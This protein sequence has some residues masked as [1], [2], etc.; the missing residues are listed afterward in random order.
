[1]VSLLYCLHHDSTVRQR[2]HHTNPTIKYSA[3]QDFVVREYPFLKSNLLIQK[4]TLWKKGS[5]LSYFEA[6]PHLS[7][8]I[9]TK[10]PQGAKIALYYKCTY[11]C[12]R[13][14]IVDVYRSYFGCWFKWTMDFMSCFCMRVSG[15][16]LQVYDGSSVWVVCRRMRVAEG[17]LSRVPPMFST[18]WSWNPNKK[19]SA[20][21]MPD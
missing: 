12:C 17:R 19:I 1:M 16:W 10:V 6:S 14:V 5:Q 18:G 3:I 2:F 4:L 20:N 21:P 13:Y 11:M 15:Y 8:C 9:L 7:V